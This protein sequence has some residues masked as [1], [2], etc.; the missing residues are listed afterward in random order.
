[1]A[2]Y[3]NSYSRWVAWL[4]VLLPLIALGILSTL[5]LVSRQ[6][7]PESAI[8]YSEVEVAAILR[9]QRIERPDYSGVTDDGAAL[10]L[11][12]DTARPGDAT[13]MAAQGLRAR[14]ESPD[15]GV[16]SLRAETG[17]IDTTGRQ[18]R[19][20]GGVRMLTSTGYVIETEG[21]TAAL[22]VTDL[23][24]T[25]EI[26]AI[27]PPGRL[28]AGEMRLTRHSG[29][30]YL[31]VFNDRVRLVYEPDQTQGGGP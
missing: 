8:P 11:A 23:R 6:T 21:F 17:V 4:K 15:G 3:D 31:I 30:R 24:S 28:T 10:T 5:F 2:T 16:V 19:M 13:G 12:A 18:A 7:D 27:G 22:D 9:E 26:S 20:E 29:S 14:L 25:G 1:M